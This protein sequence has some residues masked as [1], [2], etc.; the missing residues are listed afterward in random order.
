MNTVSSLNLNQ[1]N[2]AREESE[3]VRGRTNERDISEENL[4]S[5]NCSPIP[6]A[7]KRGP[8]RPKGSRNKISRAKSVD[9][10]ESPKRRGRPPGTGHLQKER[11]WPRVFQLKSRSPKA[12]LGVLGNSQRPNRSQLLL[13]G[14]TYT[15]DDLARP[16]PP[17]TTTTSPGS[18]STPSPS[19][20][21]RTTTLAV[22]VVVAVAF[23]FLQ[24]PLPSTRLHHPTGHIHLFPARRRGFFSRKCPATRA[25][26]YWSKTEVGEKIKT[27][28]PLLFAS[29]LSLSKLYE[30][31]SERRSKVFGKRSPE[32]FGFWDLCNKGHQCSTETQEVAEE[33]IRVRKKPQ[34]RIILVESGQRSYGSYLATCTPN[35][36]REKIGGGKAT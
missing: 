32:N 19:L 28:T 25:E 12:Q 8:G 34:R 29:P 31:V 13:A 17:T 22:V 7:V 15:A 5:R 16:L 24:S 14:G 26:I 6:A 9:L 11:P 10:D 30:Q 18:T 21:S 27:A 23:A 3:T 1:E 20:S 4:N 35:M 36:G 33:Q 2:Q